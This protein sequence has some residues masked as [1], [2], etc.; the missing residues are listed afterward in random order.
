MITVCHHC[1][2]FLCSLTRLPG[3]ALRQEA[4]P[5]RQDKPRRPHSGVILPL[6]SNLQHNKTVTA[7]FW[8][9]LSGN[10]ARFSL[11]ARKRFL[12]SVSSCIVALCPSTSSRDYL[13]YRSVK[14]LN[15][16][17]HGA[18]QSNSRLTDAWTVSSTALEL[19]RKLNSA[20]AR[21]GPTRG[22]PSPFI[23]C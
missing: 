3:M 13:K 11:L 22:G 16:L 15:V 21:H 14:K 12:Q 18:P 8:H 20:G 19:D 6:P 10:L 7:S 1:V 17:S 23:M 5:A 4:R 9:W 2:I